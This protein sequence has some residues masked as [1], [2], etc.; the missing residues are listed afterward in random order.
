MYTPEFKAKVARY[1]I[2]NGNCRAARKFSTILMKLLTRVLFKG[3]LQRTRGRWK[4]NEK[5]VRKFTA[6][7]KNFSKSRTHSGNL[8]LGKI[9]RYMVAVC[10]CQV[11]LTL[12]SKY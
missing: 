7:Q 8:H 1:A 12:M 9:T 11:M 2:E 3:G 5:L 6:A 10:L 4:G